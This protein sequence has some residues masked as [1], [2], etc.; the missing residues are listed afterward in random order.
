[1]NL[2][3]SWIILGCVV[4]SGLAAAGT[5]AAWWLI[6]R[7]NLHLWLGSYYF[8]GP[9][10]RTA[11]DEGRP[12]DIFIAVCDH[13][14]PEWG[15]ADRTTALARVDR[16]RHHYDS[17]F[18]EFC[19]SRGRPPQ[20]TF[21]F[22]QDQYAP[23]YLDRLAGLCAAGFGDVDV[24]LHH[25]N[26]TA[27]GL[28]EKLDRFRETLY[29]RHGLLRRDPSTGEIV[30]GFIHG[31]WALCNSRPD[32]RWCGVDH[33]IPI[34]RETGCYADFT[35]PSAPTD[36]Q[37]R[38]INSIYYA[39]DQPG[40]RKSHDAGVRARVGVPAPAGGLLMIQGPLEL[41][42]RRR[43]C[44]F[45]PR[46][47]NG[48]IHARNHPSRHRF[49]LWR[50]ARVHVAG[51]P[52]W[53]FIKL[54]THGCKDGNLEMLLGEPMRQFHRQLAEMAAAD[55]TFRYHYVTAWE[56]AQLVHQ[57]ER[58]ASSPEL[59]TEYAPARTPIDA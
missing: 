47:E 28:R 29:Y 20:H 10:A 8:P 2:D 40:R 44:G 13:F 56:M 16:W 49:Q 14:E 33:E 22:P 25:D 43:R 3:L 19:D 48:D 36:T 52:E 27:G 23:V 58:G 12:T 1:M 21:F 54:H 6:R 39:F 26:D 9:G 35:M 42:W 53:Q 37:T 51:R 15:R 17:L 4:V 55:G 41:D 38:T 5:A 32:G 30:Y 59:C 46:I 11:P 7:R 31:N 24:H 18:S 50:E 45:L 34:L 57:A